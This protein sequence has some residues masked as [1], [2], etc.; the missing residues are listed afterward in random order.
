M[1]KRRSA[2]VN[3]VQNLAIALLTMS[4]LFLSAS[5]PL[6]GPLSDKSLVDLTRAR[7]QH[8]TTNVRSETR[9]VTTLA[10]PVRI[11]FTNSYARFASDALTT[12]SDDFE[13]AGTYL[14]EA[15]GSA[16]DMARVNERDFLAALRGSG[17]YFDFTAALPVE[18]LCSWFGVAIPSYDLDSVRRALLC[19]AEGDDAVLY[20]Q[21]GAHVCRRFETAVQSSALDDYLSALDGNGAEFA[22]S[23]GA[24]YAALSP[25]TIALRE[26]DRREV[27]SAALALNESAAT[28]FLRRAGFSTRAENRFIEASGTVLVREVS[29]TLYLHPNGT[30]AYQGGA[31]EEGS[32]Y[33]VPAAEASAPTLTEAVTAAQE[34]ALTLLGDLSGDASLYLSGVTRRV[35]GYEVSFDYL[36]GGT[37]VRFADG[38]HAMTLTIDGQ[39]V[40]AFT[41]RARHYALTGESALQLPLLQAAAV[42]RVYRNAE[43]SVAYVDGG[44]DTVE[45][46]WVAD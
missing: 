37:P 25:Y 27:L 35:G 13:H 23:L 24:N 2:A 22:Q 19:P 20:L 46:I 10:S 40:T 15:I 8:E 4:A 36:V 31:A 12:Y 28:A 42:A 44:G 29:G 45:P 32:L 38:A 26:P 9:E 21:N 6:F 1:D 41:L 11:V 34:L 18:V 5:L 3:R 16:H 39:S 17:L 30:A 33:F 43:L 7:L 14:G